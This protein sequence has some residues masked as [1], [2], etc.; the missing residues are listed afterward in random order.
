MKMGQSVEVDQVT[1]A[2]EAFL[3]FLVAHAV[4]F[5]VASRAKCFKL[6]LLEYHLLR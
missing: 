3:S 2:Q 6:E 1:T 4:I 5:L